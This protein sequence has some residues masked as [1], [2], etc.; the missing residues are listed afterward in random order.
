MRYIAYRI[1]FSK[2]CDAICDV[3]KILRAMLR[4]DV[5]CLNLL[6]AMRCCYAMYRIERHS[7]CNYFSLEISITLSGEIGPRCDV[8]LWNLKLSHHCNNNRSVG[9]RLTVGLCDRMQN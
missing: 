1:A 5:F 7:N 8:I 9:E 6:R 2:F 4:C 3:S